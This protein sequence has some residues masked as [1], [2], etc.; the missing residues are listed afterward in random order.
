MSGMLLSSMGVQLGMITCSW[1][2]RSTSAGMLVEGSLLGAGWDVWWGWTCVWPVVW[3]VVEVHHWGS[4]VSLWG[5][6][7]VVQPGDMVGCMECVGVHLQG[8][9]GIVHA[10]QYENDILV[11][12]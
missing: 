8:G 9:Q 5:L 7:Y 1:M 10:V 6:G 4:S 2:P 3:G 12:V 11:G